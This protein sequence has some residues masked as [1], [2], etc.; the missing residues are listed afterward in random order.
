[1]KLDLT[2]LEW[3]FLKLELRRICIA[4]NDAG[5]PHPA[6]D[7]RLGV[8]RTLQGKLKAEASA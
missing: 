4:E 3:E 1:M 8:A 2:P 7:S 5:R 6:F